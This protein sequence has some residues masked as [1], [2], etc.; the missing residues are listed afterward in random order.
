MVCRPE[1]NI[2]SQDSRNN[3]Y[4]NRRRCHH[5]IPHNRDN[6]EDEEEQDTTTVFDQAV[7]Q[8]QPLQNAIDF[9]DTVLGWIPGLGWLIDLIKGAVDAIMGF[10]TG[11]ATF[12]DNLETIANDLTTIIDSA[13]NIRNSLRDLRDSLPWW[14]VISR[15]ALSVLI[16]GCNVLITLASPIRDF[17]NAIIGLVAAPTERYT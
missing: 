1:D 8:M 10:L 17:L 5:N 12:F 6:G 11:I 7:E 4:L 16:G 2:Y 3:L 14:R 9:I 13:T 15:A